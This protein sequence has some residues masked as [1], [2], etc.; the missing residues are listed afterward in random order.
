M[1]TVREESN[2]LWPTQ[3]AMIGGRTGGAHRKKSF[4]IVCAWHDFFLCALV[5]KTIKQ[6]ML[7]FIQ[8]G[9]VKP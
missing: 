5:F 9:L 2:K 8:L 6:F 7:E 3:R 4:V 1:S